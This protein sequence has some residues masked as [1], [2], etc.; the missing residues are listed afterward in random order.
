MLVYSTVCSGGCVS[1]R[2]KIMKCWT[3]EYIG[4]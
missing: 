2:V 3:V 1:E 4:I